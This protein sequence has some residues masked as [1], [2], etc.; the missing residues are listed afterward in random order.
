MS[1]RIMPVRNVSGTVVQNPSEA[2]RSTYA[3]LRPPTPDKSHNRTSSEIGQ[4]LSASD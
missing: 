3:H 2:F 1:E 4:H